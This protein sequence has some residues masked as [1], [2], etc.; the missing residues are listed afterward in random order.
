MDYV[1]GHWFIGGYRQQHKHNV[2][3]YYKCIITYLRPVC[4]YMYV[5][6]YSF[7]FFEI[8]LIQLYSFSSTCLEGGAIR[9][10]FL[11]NVLFLNFEACKYSP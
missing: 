3:V 8:Y 7:E 1:T 9:W 6:D 11:G 5:T 4:Y 2:N 10:Y